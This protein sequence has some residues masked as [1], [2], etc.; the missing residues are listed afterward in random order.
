MLSYV[1]LVLGSVGIILCFYK[2]VSILMLKE[3]TPQ[4]FAGTVT[5]YHILISGY[6]LACFMLSLTAIIQSILEHESISLTTLFMLSMATQ[7]M[8][9]AMIS[10]RAYLCVVHS[11][12]LT[13]RVALVFLTVNWLLLP[14]PVLYLK[15]KNY[16][17]AVLF[18]VS[19]STMIFCYLQVYL[20]TRQSTIILRSMTFSPQS[21]SDQ[22]SKHAILFIF[23]LVLGHVCI[24]RFQD[25]DSPF[26]ILLLV[27]SILAPLCYKETK[28][29]AVASSLQQKPQRSRR[30][31]FLFDPKQIQSIQ[32]T[33]RGLP[34][35]QQPFSPTPQSTSPNKVPLYF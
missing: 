5:S 27:H 30:K 9:A 19:L 2:I 26:T 15:K 32:V 10:I 23:I 18:L 13:N 14:L 22:V 34:E 7:Y 6:C 4:G 3:R 25:I 33:S 11:Y 24:L 20:V 12:K 28:V 8:T 17:L 1:N 31:T 35:Q 21:I 29:S 16:L